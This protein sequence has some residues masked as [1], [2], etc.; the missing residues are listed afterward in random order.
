MKQI[1][2]KC[3]GCA[4][5]YLVCPVSAISININD[6]GF[7]QAYMDESICVECGK[8][9]KICKDCKNANYNISDAFH[10]VAVA[11]DRNI[12]KKSSSGG[13][14]FILASKF[15]ED[16]GIV[17][18]VGY[19]KIDNN[20]QHYL[21]SSVHELEESQGS[22]YLQ[23]YNA[24]AFLEV[25]QEKKKVLITGTP[26]QIAGFREIIKYRNDKDRFLLIDIFCHGV[27][28]TKLWRNHL[29][30]L[31]ISKDYKTNGAPKFRKNKKFLLIMND[32]MRWYNQDG[33]LM[34][35]LQN[36][37]LNDSCYSCPYRRCSSADIRLG[38]LMSNK[39]DNLWYSPSCICVNTKKGE[40][41]LERIKDQLDIFQVDYSEIDEIQEKN[42]FNTAYEVNPT[43]NRLDEP[44]I[45]PKQ[46]LGYK[47]YVNYVKSLIKIPLILLKER[48][49]T[50]DLSRVINGKMK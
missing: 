35:F 13:L 14:G 22:K 33:F 26:C 15:I 30:E 49:M 36:R 45:T 8:C 34:L 46:L 1:F 21:F 19:N 43:Y 41:Y 38:D 16:D 25:L 44:T 12:L 20:A 23:S 31:Q 3:S 10:Y 28:S 2:E 4:A 42:K 27:P 7:F 40:E 47:F 18:A 29:K 24:D 37:F 5:C 48:V 17:C 39:Y 50:D 6:K 32:Y 9:K 11:K